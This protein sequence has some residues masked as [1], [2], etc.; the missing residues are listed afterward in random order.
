MSEKMT[1]EHALQRLEEIADTLENGDLELEQTMQLFEEANAL[2]KY[3][4]DKVD[5]AEEKLEI[6][7]KKDDGFHLTVEND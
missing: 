5:K 7:L 3:C 1:F 4:N 6:L 2:S